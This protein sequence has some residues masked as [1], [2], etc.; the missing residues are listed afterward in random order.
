MNA[1]DALTRRQAIRFVRECADRVI[2]Q[3]T[4][5]AMGWDKGRFRDDDVH[6]HLSIEQSVRCDVSFAFGIAMVDG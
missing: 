4:R 2:E 3:R 5:Q 1:V 6:C